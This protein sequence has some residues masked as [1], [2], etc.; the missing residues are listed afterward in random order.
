M[1]CVNDSLASRPQ[2]EPTEFKIRTLIN[3]SLSQ[4]PNP[5]HLSSVAPT[6]TDKHNSTF[7]PQKPF[8]YGTTWW[9]GE[10]RE[11]S[12][13]V[14]SLYNTPTKHTPKNAYTL[15]QILRLCTSNI[16]RPLT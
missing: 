2:I 9:D 5:W 6:A 13:F 12:V 7:M 16:C 15:F 10:E 11:A 1:N 8:Q 3:D 4:V 14:E